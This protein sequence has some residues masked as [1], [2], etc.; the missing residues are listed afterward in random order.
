MHEMSIAE[1]LLKIVEENAAK[2]NSRKVISINIKAGAMRGIVPDTLDLCFEIIARGTIAENARL[3]VEEIPLRISCKNCFHVFTPMDFI[4]ICPK[5]GMTETEIISGM[6]L[7]VQD[8][9]IE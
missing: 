2:H 9:E 4:M 7:Y 5:C 1:A 6:E 3:N 8:I